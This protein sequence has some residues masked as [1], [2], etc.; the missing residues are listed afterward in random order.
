[1]REYRPEILLL[2][3]MVAT[4]TP[5]AYGTLLCGMFK[6]INYNNQTITAD[7]FHM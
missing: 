7:H 4:V 6:Q 2:S 3:T 5:Q 1:M